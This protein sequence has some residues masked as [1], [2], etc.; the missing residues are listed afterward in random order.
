MRTYCLLPGPDC[1]HEVSKMMDSI[2]TVL[3]KGHIIKIRFKIGVWQHTMDNSL[4][5]SKPD[6]IFCLHPWWYIVCRLS[7][8]MLYAKWFPDNVAKRSGIND[9]I[10]FFSIGKWGLILMD[11]KRCRPET[12]NE[13]DVPSRHLVMTEE[14]VGKF[15]LEAIIVCFQLLG[16]RLKLQGGVSGGISFPS[17][18]Q[19]FPEN[20]N[21]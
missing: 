7:S 13:V 20:S 10:K 4:G 14:E 17:S 19:I 12:K 1:R 21:N 16:P 18:S 15:E 6:I 3:L 5:V 9:I 2:G 8:I 11:H